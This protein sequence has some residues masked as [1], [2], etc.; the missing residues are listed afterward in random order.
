MCTVYCVF[1]GSKKVNVEYTHNNTVYVE[2][3]H[4][5]TVYV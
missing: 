5:N 2:Y 4:K 3:T 1:L